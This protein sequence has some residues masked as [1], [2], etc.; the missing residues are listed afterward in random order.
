MALKATSVRLDED[1][2]ERIGQVAVNTVLKVIDTVELIL[3]QHL[4]AGREAFY[5]NA[6]TIG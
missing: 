3:P 6:K 2:L 4:F 1:T 5:I